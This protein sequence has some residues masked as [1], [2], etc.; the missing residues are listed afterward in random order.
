MD[1]LAVTALWGVAMMLVGILAGVV[2]SDRDS[3]GVAVVALV[4][5]AAGFL[6][7]AVAGFLYFS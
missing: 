2:A 3:R 6:V 5:L 1:P 7:I 4:L